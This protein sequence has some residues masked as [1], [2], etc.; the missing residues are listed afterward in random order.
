MA[1]ETTSHNA[2]V[3]DGLTWLGWSGVRVSQGANFQKGLD[4]AKSGD[5]ATAL[6]EWTTLLK[7]DVNPTSVGIIAKCI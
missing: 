4:P 7:G 5:F 2:G 3:F 1:D 6:G